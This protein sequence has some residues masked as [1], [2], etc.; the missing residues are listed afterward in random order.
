MNEQL[1]KSFSN[2]ELVKSLEG[3]FEI[4]RKNSHS[5]LL[6]LKEIQDRKLY[7][8]MGFSSLFEMLIKYFKQSETAANQRRYALRLMNDVPE[9]KERLIEGNLNLSTLALAQRQIQREEKVTGVKVDP[10]KKSEIV[11]RI[12][13][14][15]IAQAEKELMSLLP[16]SSKTLE[17]KERRISADETRLSITIPD[18]VKEKMETLKNRWAAVNVNMDQLELIER[19]L[20]IALTQTNPG[21]KKKH[22]TTESVVQSNLKSQS[23]QAASTAPVNKSQKRKTYYSIKI[24]KILWEKANSQCEYIDTIS[25]RRCQSKFGL[26]RD[27]IIPLAKGGSNDI[28]NLRLL[29][30]THNQLMARRHYG[31]KKAQGE[32]RV[33][34][35]QAINRPQSLP[36]RHKLDSRE[37][38]PYELSRDLIKNN[39]FSYLLAHPLN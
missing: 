24:D 10:T 37:K 7:A 33:L 26:E 18:R 20:D 13:S 21:P 17:T 29:C 32:K 5:I 23:T 27:H 9:I 22:R 8:D 25:G 12:S 6:H 30:R 11:E 31:A 2:H 3:H 4:E 19:A 16:E 35:T 28:K 34:Q 1:I 39:T 14:K 36:K 15:T 38:T